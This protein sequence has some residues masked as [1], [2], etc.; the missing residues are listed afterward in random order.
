MLRWLSEKPE[1][2]AVQADADPSGLKPNQRVAV[3]ADDYAK[4]PIHGILVAADAE[5]VVIRHEADRV[6]TVH[7]HFPRFG[8]DVLPA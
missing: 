6:G 1:V 2:P 5:E 3:S 7:V 4:E 8:Y